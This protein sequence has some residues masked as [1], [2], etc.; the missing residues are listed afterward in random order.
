MTQLPVLS[1]GVTD[2]DVSAEGRWIL[3][4]INNYIR[5]GARVTSTIR[6]GQALPTGP[7]KTPSSS[8]AAAFTVTLAS[9]ITTTSTFLAELR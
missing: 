2:I 6:G 5:C 1:D 8:Y 9:S 4:T 3:G 7:L